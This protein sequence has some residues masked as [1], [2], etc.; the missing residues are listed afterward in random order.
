MKKDFF[1]IFILLIALFIPT[2]FADINGVWHFAQDVRGGIFGSD[3]QAI[4][5]SYTFIN[6]VYFEKNITSQ[7]NLI[8]N[9]I[10]AYDTNGI[11]IKTVNGNVSFFIKN[12]GNIG[13]GTD[14]P[15]SKLTIQGDVKAL[16]YYHISDYRLKKDIEKIDNS[17]E[18]LLFLEGVEFKWNNDLENKTN[19][20]FIAQD[21][22][23]I[24]PE[25]VNTDLEGYKSVDYSS[26]VP[27]LVEAIK[28]QQIEIEK[29]KNE[30]N[31]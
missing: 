7:K 19:L 9:N 15:T 27:L 18:K 13:I 8:V 20:G 16:A 31:N 21:V 28:S 29:L 14:N 24:I 6:P 12:N 2:I 1:I 4:T 23:K 17:L 5:S 25:V 22:E 26:L 11:R 30:I 10:T 3:E